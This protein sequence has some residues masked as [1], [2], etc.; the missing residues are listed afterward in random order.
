MR[1]IKQLRINYI[2]LA[3]FVVS[4]PVMIYGIRSVTTSADAVRAAVD[5]E[6]RIHEFGDEMV[7][8]SDYLTNK[9]RAFVFTGDRTELLAFWT[10]VNT[11]QGREVVFAQ[12]RA[13]GLDASEE[14]H[15]AAAKQ[16]SDQLIEVESAAM[17]L[18]EEAN[19]VAEKD[20]PARVAAVELSEEDARLSAERKLQKARRLVFGRNY[21]GAKSSIYRE[22]RSFIEIAQE[23]T[24]RKLE[25]ARTDSSKAEVALFALIFCSLFGS[26]LVMLLNFLNIYLPMKRYTDLLA[27]TGGG[28]VLPELPLTGCME[29]RNLASALNDRAEE[30]TLFEKAMLDTQLRLTAHLRLMPLA[31]V[32]IDGKRRIAVWNPAAEKTF[33]WAESEA[34]GK[35]LVDLIVPER[36]REEI[37]ALMD[38]L[39][40]GNEVEINVNANIRKDGSE[41]LCEWYNTP[42]FDSEG[43]RIGWAS[44]VRD[45][46]DERKEEERILYL[47]R[48]DPLT[49]L[50][51]RRYMT[52]RLD[53]EQRRA[54]R[55]GK[56]YSVLM[57][58]IDKFKSFNDEHGHECGDLVLA[59]VAAALRSAVRATDSVSRWGGEEFL[60]LL[61]E[62]G[63]EGARETAEKIRSEVERRRISYGGLRLGVTLSVGSSSCPSPSIDECIR[64]ADEA[65]L[66]AKAAGRNR[67]VA[68]EL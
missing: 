58:D 50:Y 41:L 39:D 13:L 32:E 25:D 52:E 35:R 21:E 17:R 38:G 60:V 62:T 59:E 34:L 27:G 45:I 67:V 47:S 2:A 9:V 36:L 33:G 48:H 10:E 54:E 56:A 65:L 43:K 5:E 15:L 14:S 16:L 29:L 4:I 55:S 64:K 6:R 11:T 40:K 8:L 19:G 31:A 61:P 3:V 46:T 44:M 53:E 7:S 23:R 20:M 26:A 63:S 18:V 51:N 12:L 37:N 22:V 30:R 57:A 24:S 66:A 68:A 49:D 1:P 42:L 28:R